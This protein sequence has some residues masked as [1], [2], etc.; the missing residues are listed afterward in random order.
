MN[1]WGTSWSDSDKWCSKWS[2]TVWT[3]SYKFSNEASTRV[4]YFLS[5]SLKSRPP[6]WMTY[7]GRRISMS[8]SK[9]TF[10]QLH[11]IFWSQ[12]KLSRITKLGVQTPQTVNLDEVVGDKTDSRNKPLRF[13]PLTHFLWKI[14]PTN[15][16]IA[17]VQVAKAN[18]DLSI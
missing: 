13:T 1:H 8:L 12:T 5:P 4:F 6:Q 2:P 17:K 14:P 11:N 10:K 9:I 18:Q 3:L 16:E 15:S 7:S